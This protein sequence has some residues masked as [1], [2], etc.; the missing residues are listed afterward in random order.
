MAIYRDCFRPSETLAEPRALLTV[1][2][3]CADTEAEADTLGTSLDLAWLRLFAGRPGPLPS[4]REAQ[5]HPYT[6]AERAQVQVNR[7]RLIWG[8]PAGVQ[9]QLCALAG[10]PGVEEV[11]VTTMVH[12]HAA[13]VRSYELLARTFGTG[14]DT[15]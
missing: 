10:R 5:E 1:S 3:V 12:D 9:A 15:G 2:A 6:A 7:D 14:R 13:R 11:M 8:D 4:V